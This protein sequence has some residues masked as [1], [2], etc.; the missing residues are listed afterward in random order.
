MTLF[1]LFS[2]IFITNLRSPQ[3]LSFSWTVLPHIPAA[4]GS[5]V[6]YFSVVLSCSLYFLKIH[7]SVLPSVFYGHGIVLI[8]SSSLQADWSG[9]WY[10]AQLYIKTETW[11]YFC[12][13][14]SHTHIYMYIYIYIFILHC[15]HL[16]YAFLLSFI[17][18]HNTYIWFIFHRSNR[19]TILWGC[20][21]SHNII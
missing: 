18:Q 12:F 6:E 19:N 7:L 2:L 3:S 20:G 8:V 1:L 13:S 4:T 14:F 15:F 17:Y 21:N 10:P 16:S 5:Y 9:L 11:S